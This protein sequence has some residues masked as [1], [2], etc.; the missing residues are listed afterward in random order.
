MGGD[1]RRARHALRWAGDGDSL[2]LC[3]CGAGGCLARAPPAYYPG[4]TPSMFRTQSASQSR[5][6]SAPMGRTGSEFIYTS[7]H[8]CRR[9][10]GVVVR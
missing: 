3:V 5:P 8:G 6:T 2:V 9:T 4:S 1:A 10:R 7:R